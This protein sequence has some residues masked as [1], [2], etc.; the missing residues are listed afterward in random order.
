MA[1]LIFYGSDA[2]TEAEAMA[3]AQRHLGTDDLES[4]MFFMRYREKVNMDDTRDM[5][6][7]LNLKADAYVVWFDKAET[8]SVFCQNAMLKALE[9]REDVLFIFMAAGKLLATVESRCEIRRGR[10]FSF[11]DFHRFYP[12]KA[13]G[14]YYYS[15][16]LE[17][18][19][20]EALGDP[21]VQ[22]IVGKTED[23]FRFLDDPADVLAT[24]GMLKEKDTDSFIET[25]KD[26]VSN[27]YALFEGVL[28]SRIDD[29]RAMK[30]LTVVER[31][32]E[33]LRTS[34]SYGKNDFFDFLVG[35]CEKEENS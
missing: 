8:L 1:G 34:S 32:K 33:L 3:E 12:G 9:D 21:K 4:S 6:E 24:F 19:L 22:E 20:V 2:G 15:M 28:I 30:P 10:L 35:I 18:M 23:I 16:G 11:S 26:Y 27:L 14:Y 13:D 7:K 29:G 17:F 31:H 5:L 25:H